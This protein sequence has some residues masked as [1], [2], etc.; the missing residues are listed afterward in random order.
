MSCV[1]FTTSAQRS[2]YAAA[3]PV[4]L[5]A[6]QV[7]AQHPAPP[8][9]DGK[10]NRLRLLAADPVAKIREAAAASPHLPADTAQALSHDADAGVRACLARNPAVPIEILT[11]LAT[12]AE[13]GVRAWVAV[14]RSTPAGLVAQLLADP[15]ER[16]TSL[17][18]WALADRAQRD[19]VPA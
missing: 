18:E 9:T 8:V 12:D 4:A 16:V 14:N 7:A 15:N 2:Q 1:H 3:A 13:A 5:T 19:P 6:E 17:A 11:E 10:L